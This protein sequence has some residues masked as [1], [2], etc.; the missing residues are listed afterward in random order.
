MELNLK[1]GRYFLEFTFEELKNGTSRS[2]NDYIETCEH[3]KSLFYYRLINKYYNNNKIVE[4]I[5]Q[6]ETKNILKYQKFKSDYKIIKFAAK[7]NRHLL[8]Y[9][10]DELKDNYKLAKYL[11][12][13]NR[14]ELCS[15]FQ[16]NSFEL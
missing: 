6:K 10:S 9:A 12:E 14:F 3:D 2:I 15:F 13:K 5:V 1:I 8:D 7:H 11:I 4:C 16:K